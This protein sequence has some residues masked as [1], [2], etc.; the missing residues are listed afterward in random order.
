MKK[1]YFMLAAAALMFAAC[2]ET[3]FVNPVPVNE[4]E[5]IGFETY[6]NL[7]TKT[8]E[9]NGEDYDNGTMAAHHDSFSV[10]AYKNTSDL[11]V[12]GTDENTG[13]QVK[14]SD[15]SYS[16]TRYWDKTATKYEF[17]AAAPATAAWVFKGNTTNKDKAYF[18]LNDVT[19][20]AT[21][22]VGTTPS[23]SALTTFKGSGDID[24]MIADKCPVGTFTGAVQLNFIHILSRLNII[25]MK[26]NAAGTPAITLKSITVKGLNVKGS[27]NENKAAAN[28]TDGNNT[29]WT[30]ES[31][32]ADYVYASDFPLTTDENFVLQSLVIPQ[33][34]EHEAIN[35]DG[36][37]TETKPY[38]EIQYTI[39]SELFKDYYNLAAVFGS[40]GADIA[41]N[42]GWQ[43]TLKITIAPAGITF[44]SDVAAWASHLDPGVS[45]Q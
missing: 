32:T 11:L 38:L 44:T 30:P 40:T 17:Y 9:N 15:Y 18:Q 27:F 2:A 24:Y 42:E 37:S 16:P 8:T 39:N 5:V 14:S 36:S 25:V 22:F 34:I 43:N 41:F 10:W 6:A 31:V 26:S 1:N 4:G 21:N 13:T 12:F 45:I 28:N 7:S 23:T 33:D 20:S 35:R 19:L 3:D 29:R